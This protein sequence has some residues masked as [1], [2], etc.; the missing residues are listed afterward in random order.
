MK[1]IVRLSV[2]ASLT[3]LV[4]CSALP[5]RHGLAPVETAGS[6]QAATPS[7]PTALA[8]QP[9]ASPR[10][11]LLLPRTGGLAPLANA[12]HAGFVTAYQKEGNTQIPVEVIDTHEDNDVA[13]A[14]RAA[15]QQGATAIIGP[16]TK[17]G[18]QQIKRMPNLPVPVLALNYGGEVQTS[19]A[20][21]EFGLAPTDEAKQSAALALKN[22]N[23]RL[24]IL[25]VRNEW[26]MRVAN[27]FR[28]SFT[29]MGG[30]II[31]TVYFN[32]QGDIAS[33]VQRVLRINVA[34]GLSK[35]AKQNNAQALQAAASARDPN[36]GVFIAAL[37][38]QARQIKPLFAFYYA[39]KTPLYATSSVYT[40]TPNP[41]Q[42]NDLNG[43]QFCDMPWVLQSQ[44]GT[45][46]SIDQGYVRL[47]AMGMDAYRLLFALNQLSSSPQ[48]SI[49]GAT[50]QLALAPDHRVVRSLACAQFREGQPT[51]IANAS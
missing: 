13:A 41:S 8:P 2:L 19:R 31:D 25:A 36:V 1:H 45:P 26:G 18:V 47:Y 40:G 33:A 29:A 23:R 21:Y 35:K 30:Q 24:Y 49:S 6:S 43:I 50:G 17:K 38:S 22:G 7:T 12:V 44:A 14:Y 42:D 15:V 20:I 32:P 10:I 39:D 48:Q 3:L 28:D 5:T 34:G 37:P 4:A 9:G 27:S 46:Q 51:L 11:A 16:L